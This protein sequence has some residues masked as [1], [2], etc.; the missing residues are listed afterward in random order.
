MAVSADQARR[1]LTAACALYQAAPAHGLPR[2]HRNTS[3]RTHCVISAI[4]TAA[5]AAG[6]PRA[7]RPVLKR[8][9]RAAGI[10][11]QGVE[12]WEMAANTQEVVRALIRATPET[13]SELVPA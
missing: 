7:T 4:Y 13:A 12:A 8:F 2:L 1:I 10:P 3:V 11:V 9:A 6:S 5:C